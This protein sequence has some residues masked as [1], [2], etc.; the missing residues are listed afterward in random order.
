MMFKPILTAALACSACASPSDDMVGEI[1]QNGI[2]MNG[3][4]MNG[5]SMNGT[6][7]SGATI[8]GV[9]VNGT[10]SSGKALQAGSAS[11]PPLQECPG[12][13]RDRIAPSNPTGTSGT[14]RSR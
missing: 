4:S 6:N 9:G 11:A 2:S 12:T 8:T 1:T 7:L 10:S 13:R 3:I 5:I 14:L